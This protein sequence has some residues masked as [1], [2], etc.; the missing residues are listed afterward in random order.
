M[1]LD[2]NGNIL[3]YPAPKPSEDIERTFKDLVTPETSI[4]ENEKEKE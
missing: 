1:L 2:Q 4:K 3:K